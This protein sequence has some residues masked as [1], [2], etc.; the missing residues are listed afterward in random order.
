MSKQLI[1]VLDPTAPAP[2]EATKNY[3]TIENLDNKILGLV[4]NR[5]PN[6]N[7][8]LDRLEELLR[9]KL[10]FA[11]L[12]RVKKDDNDAGKGLA[13]EELD[14]LVRESQVVLNGICD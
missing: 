12:I 4:D 1:E 7:I 8:F 10:R 14:K 13:Q 9:E 2:K 5:K 3:L 6:Y 11:G